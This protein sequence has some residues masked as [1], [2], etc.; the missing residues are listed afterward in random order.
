[1]RQSKMLGSGDLI[2]L[3]SCLHANLW[4]DEKLIVNP[5][6]DEKAVFCYLIG[7]PHHNI[8]GLYYLPIMY[9]IHDMTATS[10]Q[11]DKGFTKLLSKGLIEFDEKPSLV[12]VKNYVK[13]N[14]IQ[15]PNQ[16][17]CA[18]NKL[19]DIPYTPLFKGLHEEIQRIYKPLHQPLVELLLERL[20]ERSTTEADSDSAAD[21]DTPIVKNESIFCERRIYTGSQGR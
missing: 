3:Y 14:P 20:A 11:F 12:F 4:T 13:H 8:L 17:K 2:M 7:C 5:D 21:A 9:A 6:Y 19:R 1:M 18:L 15:N 16:I 10:D